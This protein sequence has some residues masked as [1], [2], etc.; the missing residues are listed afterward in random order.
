M[1]VD[2][3]AAWVLP[4]G[5]PAGEAVAR[6]VRRAGETLHAPHLIDLEVLQAVRRIVRS[7][8]L[9]PAGAA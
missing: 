2:A 4:L 8:Q 5:T 9:T 6:I 7:G 1:V 3:S